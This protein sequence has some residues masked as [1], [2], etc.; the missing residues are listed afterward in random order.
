PSLARVAQADGAFG[1]GTSAPLVTSD[2]TN[3]GTALVWLQ[4]SA[5]NTGYGAELRA[6][7]AVPVAGKLVQR[8]RAT[9]GKATRYAPPGVGDGR[10]YVATGDGHVKA[11]GSPV[12][13]VITAPPV[14]FGVVALG[15]SAD[16]TVVFTAQRQVTVTAISGQGDF[17]VQGT[18]PPLPVSLAAGQTV[19]VQTRFTPSFAGVDA[20]AL[21]ATTDQG[22]FSTSLSGIGASTT[23]NIQPAP[24]TLSFGGLA[25]GR[26]VGSA[27]TFTNV[28]GASATILSAQ[29]PGAPF[30]VTGLPPPSTVLA[31]QQAVT[32]TIQ[33]APTQEG[34]FEDELVL[35]TDQG[36]VAVPMTGTSADIGVLQLSTTA[37]DFGQLRVGDTTQRS[38]TITN[39]GGTRLRVN[40]S[41]P[42]GLEIGFEA[43]N[44]LPEGTTLDPGASMSLQVSFTPPKNG[45]AEDRWLITADDGQGPQE[46]ALRG[47]GGEQ[48][49]DT[50][51][52][53]APGT[54]LGWWPSMLLLPWLLRRRR[55]PR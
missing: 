42:P 23:G 2:G 21:V 49:S 19:S 53:S 43:M 41:Q 38:F 8:Y 18:Q 6:Y 29:T 33:F 44:Q 7:E 37:L 34:Q 54:G 40:K 14:D 52:C 45:P 51:G 24:A 5:N 32:V 4:W 30:S 16:Q 3:P 13:P 55:A 50:G 15:S 9:I 10:I 31:P 27:V 26:T 12:D 48:S 20:A 28:G 35:A 17:S 11:F 46:V 47:T 22:P 36:A 39:V 25:I 1:L